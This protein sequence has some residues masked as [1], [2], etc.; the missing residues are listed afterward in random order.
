MNCYKPGDSNNKNGFSHGS[1]GQK[2]KTKESFGDSQGGS[3]PCLSPSP[4]AAALGLR[5]HHSDL[6]PHLPVA[7]FPGCVTDRH[8]PLV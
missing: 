4:L 6:G 5:R 7:F 3:A 1:G 8:S 2:A